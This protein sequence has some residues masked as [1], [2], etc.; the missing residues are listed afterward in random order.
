M[1]HFLLPVVAETSCFAS[2]MGSF[3]EDHLYRHQ[4]L[5]LLLAGAEQ[6]CLD[7][8]T[9]VWQDASCDCSL[10][11]DFSSL[12]PQAPDRFVACSV[13]EKPSFRA[14]TVAAKGHLLE[15][16]TAHGSQAGDAAYHTPQQEQV[17][18]H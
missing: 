7:C 4:A 16:A 10:C 5:R 6:L 2:A 8:V 9:G 17:Q 11:S 14:T 12:N 18:C 3:A 1:L 13:A 15:L